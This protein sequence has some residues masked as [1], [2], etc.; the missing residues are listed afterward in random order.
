MIVVG[1]YR[2]FRMIAAVLLII[3]LCAAALAAILLHPGTAPA[4]CA[5]P[6]AL[7]WLYCNAETSSR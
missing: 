4:E 2:R 3:A 1:R 7:R 5:A 6:G